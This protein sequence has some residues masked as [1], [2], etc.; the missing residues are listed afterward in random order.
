VLNITNGDAAVPPLRAAG[1]EGDVLPWRDVLHEG[2]VPTGLDEAELRAARARFLALDRTLAQEEVLRD[3][4]VR[5]AR[6]AK[7]LSQN[8]ACAAGERRIKRGKDAGRRAYLEGMAPT[9]DAAPRRSAAARRA[10][11]VLRQP[12]RPPPRMRR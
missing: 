2:P 6:L 10:W 5:D 7:R 1:V 9:E 12:L 8:P 11:G 4:D 3:F